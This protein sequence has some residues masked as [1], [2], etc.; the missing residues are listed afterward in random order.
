MRVD[1]LLFQQKFSDCTKYP[2]QFVLHNNRR[3]HDLFSADAFVLRI[4]F[5]VR[6][7]PLINESR[8]ALNSSPVATN[9]T[10]TIAALSH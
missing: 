6:L 4:F 3:P 9:Q 7:Q 10:I 1:Q 5:R 8:R 2:T